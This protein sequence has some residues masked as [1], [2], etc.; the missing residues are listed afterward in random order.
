MVS[1]ISD[2]L[3]VG[4]TVETPSEPQTEPTDP[5]AEMPAG[6]SDSSGSSGGSDIPAAIT[7]VTVTNLDPV[8]YETVELDSG[9]LR[10]IQQVT[11]G[12][13]LICFCLLLILAVKIGKWGWE[14]T[15]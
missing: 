9:E 10:V 2:L 3:A 11:Y 15:K 12:D 6:G 7:E 5:Q 1:G 13:I 8:K 14:S 4:E